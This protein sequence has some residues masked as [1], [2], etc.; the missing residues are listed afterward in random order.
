MRVFI[1]RITLLKEGE[2][3][4]VPDGPL[5]GR[6]LIPFLTK[7]SSDAAAFKDEF[8]AACTHLRAYCSF[9][10]ACLKAGQDTSEMSVGVASPM[11]KVLPRGPDILAAPA[12]GAVVRL[13]RNER[14]SLQI[15]V[16]PGDRDLSGV[17]V[18]VSDLRRADGVVFAATNI[19]CDV[20]GYVHIARKPPYQIGRW[21]ATNAAPSNHSF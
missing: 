17:R 8:A 10:E 14:E 16:T 6:D 5:V 21:I 18:R 7:A 19:A 20:V 12:T 1:D 13:A 15:V 11:V 4:P 9:R 3:L 2:S